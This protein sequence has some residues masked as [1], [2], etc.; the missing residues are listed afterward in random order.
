MIDWEN[1]SEVIKEREEI[2]D[3]IKGIII[4]FL[5]IDIDK[6]AISNDQPLFGRGLEL[7]SINAIDLVIGIS[8]EFDVEMDQEDII[9][10]GSTINKLTD[11]IIMKRK[12]Q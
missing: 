10:W 6:D 12:E 3:K 1:Q 5:A 2:A 9:V 8:S 4:D 7:D 11:Y